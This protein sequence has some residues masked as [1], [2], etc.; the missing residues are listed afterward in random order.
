MPTI[1]IFGAGKSA[2]CLINYLGI[3]CAK[4]QWKLLVT[5]S[6][7]ALSKS[8]TEK[9]P[10]AEAFSFDVIDK[11]KRHS[12]IKKADVVI[13]MLPPALHLLIARDCIDF[14]KH[15]FTASYIDMDLR[16]FAEDIAA[17]KLLFI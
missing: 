6:D 12:F 7:I 4:E 2:S 14:S 13:S 16:A 1:A 15:F 3:L 11:D 8:K 5:D 9:F 10:G 17:K